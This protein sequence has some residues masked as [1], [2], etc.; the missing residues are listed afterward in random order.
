[1]QSPAPRPTLSIVVVR[2]GGEPTDFNERQ[3]GALS[4]STSDRYIDGFCRHVY[5][6]LG[7]AYEVLSIFVEDGD[8][9][10]RA[11]LGSLAQRLRGR[12]RA[13]CYFLWPT[14]EQDRSDGESGMLPASAVFAA[15]RQ[16][17]AA[18]VATR[19]P[20]PPQLYSLLLSKEWQASL[21]LTKHYH[22]PHT[23]LVARGAVAADARRAARSTLETL[24][25]LALT[26]AAV[27]SQSDAPAVAASDGV[28]S[29]QSVAAPSSAPP[30]DTVPPKPSRCVAKLGHAWEANRVRVISRNE[31]PLSVAL[32]ELCREVSSEHG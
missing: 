7:P 28:Q 10:A 14:L 2:W 27:G 11:R 24:D 22:I 30:T 3:W 4:A 18:G 16:A 31:Q 20:H 19:F 6:C 15:M 26:R 13:A 25:T 1:V 8:D 23:L 29:V 21:C 9:L 32:A 17:E 12:H 5:G